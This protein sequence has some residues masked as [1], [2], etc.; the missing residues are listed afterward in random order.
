M[1]NPEDPKFEVAVVGGGMIGSAAARHLAE[2]GHSVVVIAAPEPPQWSDGDGPFAS[3]YDAGRITRVSSADPV[4]A[5]LAAR[6]IRRYA[7]I[8]ARSGISFHDPRG[9]AWIG[10]DVEAAITPAVDRGGDA[11]PVSA[12]WLAANTGIAAPPIRGLQCAYEGAP[13]GVVSPRHLVAAELRL[14]EL[15]GATIV[16]GA[17]DSLARSGQAC[18]VTG[19]FGDFAADRVLLATGAYGAQLAGVSLGMERRLRTIVRADVGPGVDIP[20]LIADDVV[21]PELEGIYWVPP[22]VYPDGS[23]LLK[24]G[25]DFLPVE[26]ASANSDIDAWFAG[27]GSTAEAAALHATMTTLLPNAEVRSWDKQPCVVTYTSTGYPHIGWIDDQVAVAVGGCGSSAKSCDELGHVA[28]M[29]LSGQDMTDENLN[30]GLF[31]ATL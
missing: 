31:S 10:H 25:G 28:A 18:Q 21:H 29:L 23:V 30:V 2:A 1:T 17:V 7:D 24:I 6:S 9:L 4:W 19:R 15:A 5:E 16:Y 26:T 11:R 14:A 3:H 20:S 27:G 13:A 12:E 22:V 8:E